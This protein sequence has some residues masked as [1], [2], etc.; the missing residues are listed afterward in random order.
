MDTEDGSVCVCMYIYTCVC[1]LRLL[2]LVLL[3][4]LLPF[5]HAKLLLH[6]V[7]Q[8]RIVFME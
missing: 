3:P 4:R 7:I 5:L 8:Q 1:L 6:P 2:E